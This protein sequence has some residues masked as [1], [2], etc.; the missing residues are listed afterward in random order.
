MDISDWVQVGLGIVLL[1]T[2]GGVLWYAWETREQR[3]ALW[4][5]WIQPQ[6]YD[7]SPSQVRLTNEGKDAYEIEALILLDRDAAYCEDAWAKGLEPT[8]ELETRN[9]ST[10]THMPNLAT[11]HWNFNPPLSEEGRY[12]AVVMYKD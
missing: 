7:Q 5:P 6:V 11:V 4:E 2:L 9:A 12:V 3:L 8:N 1:L 10:W